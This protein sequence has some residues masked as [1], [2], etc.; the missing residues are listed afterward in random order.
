[1]VA[2]LY[3][4]P[5]SPSKLVT[6]L[7]TDIDEI[8]LRCL[9]KDPSN[10]F[11]NVNELLAQLNE[12]A[13]DLPPV[14][15]GRLVADALENRRK[16][17]I[18]LR[19]DTGEFPTPGSDI[20]IEP[21]ISYTKTRKDEEAV[22]SETI[23]PPPQPAYTGG[24]PTPPPTPPPP[25]WSN[26][27]SDERPELGRKTSSSVETKL[28]RAAWLVVSSDF[29]GPSTFLLP[30]H[31][32]ARIGRGPDNDIVLIESYASRFH[33]DVECRD[34]GYYL[35]DLNTS[36]GTLVNGE[37]INEP[38]MLKD[39]DEIRIGQTILTFKIN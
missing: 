8:V 9:E 24:A 12:L 5:P 33:A 31:K 20:K 15:V 30:V 29:S 34:G 21:S 3:Q 36:N 39:N 10:R 14:D 22:S 38:V 28:P 16:E 37:R 26:H 11:H 25:G 2:N 18:H 17:A 13:N 1:M 19:T 7:P 32:K 27:S 23:E 4:S 6:E 35:R